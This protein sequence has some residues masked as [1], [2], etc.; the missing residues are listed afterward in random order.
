MD[1]YVIIMYSDYGKTVV[2]RIRFQ[3]SYRE[4]RMKANEIL[5]SSNDYMAFNVE[6]DW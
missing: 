6:F 3:G 5:Y 2:K 1:K 4:A